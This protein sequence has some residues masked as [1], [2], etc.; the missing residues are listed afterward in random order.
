MMYRRPAHPRWLACVMTLATLGCAEE[1][2]TEPPLPEI[3]VDGLLVYLPFNGTAAD[4]SGAGRH[5]TLMG[6]AAVTNALTVGAN[7]ADA[8][9][10]PGSALD[11]LGDY[12]FAAW[13]RIDVFHGDRHVI[14]SGAH[15]GEDNIVGLWYDETLAAW[16]YSEEANPAVI[17][18]SSSIQDAGWHHVTLTRSGTVA[19]LYID[20]I[21]SGPGLSVA[22]A[23]LTIDPAGL[24]IGQDQDVVGGGFEAD[25]AWAGAVDNLR[26]YDRA[27]DEPEILLIAAEAR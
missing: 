23:V 9:T 19:Q 13:L 22:G 15:A 2:P 17:S 16:R 5:A 10:I 7:A 25:E 11:G 18:A 3:P 14:L 21:A 4:G 8:L 24:V 20:G 1:S 6:G 12:T 27:L 26:I